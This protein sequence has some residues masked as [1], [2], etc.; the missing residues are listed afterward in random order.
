MSVV[1]QR[2]FQLKENENSAENFKDVPN[3]HWAKGYVKALVDN[4]ISKGDGE[5]NF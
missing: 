1:L 4:K 3:G 2:V 5:G